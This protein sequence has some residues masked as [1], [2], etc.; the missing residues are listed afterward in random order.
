MSCIGRC[1][2]YEHRPQF[3]RDY[4]RPG[5]F[6]PSGCTYTFEGNVRKGECRP[7]VC[8]ENCCCNYPREGGDPEGKSMDELAGGQPCKYLEWHETEDNEKSA[9]NLVESNTGQMYEELMPSIRGE[10]VR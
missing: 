2:I 7:E 9:S 3:C 5:D 6:L 1:G 10:H 4:P 8:E